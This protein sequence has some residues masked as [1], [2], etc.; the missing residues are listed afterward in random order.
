MATRVGAAAVTAGLLLPPVVAGASSASAGGE[1]VVRGGVEAAA[2]GDPSWLAEI[3]RYRIGAGLAAVADE[4]SWD[5]GLQAHLRYLAS[6]PASDLSGP[7]QSLHTENPASAYFSAM[8]AHEAASSEL[9]T[10]GA[11]GSAVSVI[12]RWL[13]APFHAVGMLRP[14]LR[15]VAFAQDPVTGDAALDVATGLDPAAPP[16]PSPVLFPGPGL[17]TNLTTLGAESP[18]P[19]ETCGWSGTPAGVPLVALL[20]SDPSPGLAASLV[21]P[22]GTVDTTA[23]G[24]LCV[25]DDHTYRSS[26][27]V[28]G[29]EGAAILSNDHAVFL[30][31]RHPLAGGGT[32]VAIQATITQ[33][34]QGPITWS[35]SEAATLPGTATGM[36][37]TPDGRGYWLVDGAGQVSNHGDAGYYGSTMGHSLNSPISHI[38]ATPDGGGYWLVAADG[39]I[40]TFGDAGFY[41]SMGASHLNAPVVDLAATPD[42]GGYWL[43]AADGGIFTFGDAGFYGSMGASHLN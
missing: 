4:P 11:T 15:Q 20:P 23:N 36:A 40:F 16:D 39:G 10:G 13:Q 3:N 12:D 34:G 37:S 14:N 30:I 5:A 9:V 28:Y 7:Y 22:D 18:D 32:N 21:E 43:V 1:G 25:V 24:G 42:G 38:V 26:N 6:T 29:Q 19:L 2:A 33:P 31:P 17:L 8:G 27:A 35:F 41:G